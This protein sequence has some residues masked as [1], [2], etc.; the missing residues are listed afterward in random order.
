VWVA[1]WSETETARANKQVVGGEAETPRAGRRLVVRDGDSSC[2]AET[3]RAGRKLVGE[4]T[5]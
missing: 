4:A 1:S 5:P 2:E 3:P